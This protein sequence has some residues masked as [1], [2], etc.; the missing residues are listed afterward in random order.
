VVQYKKAEPVSV[1]TMNSTIGGDNPSER[2]TM[3]IKEYCD[4]VNKVN[5]EIPPNFRRGQYAYIT[6]W[7]TDKKIC[8]DVEGIADPY[9]NDGNIPKFLEALKSHVHIQEIDED[10]VDQVLSFYE[11]ALSWE[12]A[13]TSDGVTYTNHPDMA[14]W[15][16]SWK[17]GTLS[18]SF[19]KEKYAKLE[20]AVVGH[21]YSQGVDVA[22]ALELARSYAATIQDR[23]NK[24]YDTR[25]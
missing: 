16:M 24:I 23:E 14:H 9:H 4:F 19:V 2:K 5:G 22:L 15:G 13:F 6:L 10:N 18:M 8:S 17:H 21:L 20:A 3:D 11:I 12:D 7:N 1:L 25:D